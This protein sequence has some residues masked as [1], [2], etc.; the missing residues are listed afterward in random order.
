MKHEARGMSHLYPGQSFGEVNIMR[1]EPRDATI[2]AKE[3]CDLWTVSR[4]D[5]IA[6]FKE[7]YDR[8][9]TERMLLL[10]QV[11]V[12]QFMSEAERR[13]LAEVCMPRRFAR[14]KVILKE[15]E[16]P[17]LMYIVASGEASVIMTLVYQGLARFVEIAKVTT[18]EY[19]GE[20]GLLNLQPRRASVVAHTSMEALAINQMD[21][22][23]YLTGSALEAIKEHAKGYAS[24]RDIFQLFQQEQTW[25]R[26]KQDLVDDILFQRARRQKGR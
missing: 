11:P 3:R 8:D 12:M 18:G 26:Y 16:D 22:H 5:Y 25:E 4:D 9:I 19:F 15:G 17:D 10:L 21:F 14:N 13:R 1:N 23:L 2:L 24:Y 20:L 7:Y 6:I